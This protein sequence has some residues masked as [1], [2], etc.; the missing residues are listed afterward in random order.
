[1]KMVLYYFSGTGNTRFIA[2]KFLEK[3]VQAGQRLAGSAG[4]G[5]G[6]EPVETVL[7]PVDQAPRDG[8]VIEPDTI[9]GIGFPVYDLMPPE[10]VCSFVQALPDARPGQVAFV[11]STYT[12]FPL[13]ANR[14]VIELLQQKGYRVVAEQ[15]FKAPGAVA[16]VYANPELPV[17]RGEAVFEKGVDR[18]IESFLTQVLAGVGDGAPTIR[19]RPHPLRKFHQAVSRLVMG[20]LFYRNLRVTAECTGCGL[21]AK[22]CPSSNLTLEG[23]TLRVLQ[24]NG[25]LR[26]MRCVGLCPVR[27]INFTSSRRRGD[28]TRSTIEMLYNKEC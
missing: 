22:N 14:Y 19:I 16:Y 4:S 9:F 25:C 10:I 17:I 7:L 8:I 15:N 26:C 21:C 11:F 5:T 6:T 1:M 24:S 13:D 12:S 18:A 3:A 27:A 2:E 20:N 28:Y 23:G